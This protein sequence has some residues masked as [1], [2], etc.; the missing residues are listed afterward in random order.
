M[1]F[2]ECFSN[3]KVNT[4]RQPEIDCLKA[5]CIVWMI[6]LHTYEDLASDT[7][8]IS[9]TLDYICEFVGAAA[10]MI[11][12]GIGIRYSRSQE[13]GNYIHRGFEIFTVG[14]LLNLL[15]NSIPNLIAYWIKGDDFFIANSLL[16]IQ[17]DILSF[18]GLAFILIALFK[19]LRISDNLILGAGILMNLVGL[20]LYL[21]FNGPVIISNFLLSQLAGYFVLTN[22]EAFFPLLSYFIFVAF[23]YFLG[24]L[25]PRISDKNKLSTQL[26]Y[27]CLPLCVIY[28]VL[29]SI[30]PFPGLPEFN[31]IEQYCIYPGP[32]ALATCLVSVVMLSLFYKMTKN[33][34]GKIWGP[35]SHLSR[36]INKYYC[37]SYIFILPLQTV[38][39]AVQGSLMPGA[40]LPTVYGIFVIIACVFIIKWNDRHLHFG[41]AGLKGPKRAAAFTAIYLVSALVIIYAYPRIDEFATLWTRYLLP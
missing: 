23:G 39:I 40:M 26:L 20:G 29:R 22:A 19:K 18:A 16:V 1:R 33:N 2:K 7:N 17:A 15:R 31:S 24:G 3:E 36:N 11:C 41:I 10:F 13:P 27:I 32:D 30:Y 35:V 38:L 12:M 4:G 37:I 8:L 28:Y 34:S 9:E 6:L 14:Q 25:Y 5:F 21:V